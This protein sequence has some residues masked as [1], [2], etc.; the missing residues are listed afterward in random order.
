MDFGQQL[1]HELVRRMGSNGNW[2]KRTN[3]TGLG[4]R[5]S[6]DSY[7]GNSIQDDTELRSEEEMHESHFPAHGQRPNL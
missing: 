7:R 2:R 6:L 5:S 3:S 1:R 4:G